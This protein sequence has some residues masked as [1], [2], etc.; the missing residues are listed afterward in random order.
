MNETAK[1]IFDIIYFKLISSNTILFVLIDYK[2][3]YLYIYI[4]HDIIFA[5]YKLNSLV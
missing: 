1:Y 4:Y 5:N 3:L 2:Q